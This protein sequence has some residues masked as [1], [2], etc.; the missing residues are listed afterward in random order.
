[1]KSFVIRV[2]IGMSILLALSGCDEYEGVDYLNIGHPADPGAPTG[3][4]AR[5][6]GALVSENINVSPQLGSIGRS[7]SQMRT[8]APVMNGS[9]MDHSKMDH[10]KMKQPMAKQPKKAPAMDHRGSH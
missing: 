6:S 8:G 10:S 2:A 9:Q 1:M 7:S 5:M 3:K 4:R